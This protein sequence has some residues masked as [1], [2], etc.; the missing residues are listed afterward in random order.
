[1]L[2]KTS[3][4]RTVW[5]IGGSSG[6]G[7]A[8]VKG[9]NNSG[10]NVVAGARSFKN[11]ENVS[12]DIINS[13]INLIPLDVTDE[14]SRNNFTEE[15]LKLFPKVDALVYCAGTLLFGPCE[16]TTCNEYS[17]IMNTNFIGTVAMVQQILPVFRKQN[18]GKIIL[19]SSINGLLG[20]PFQSA[21]VA[22]KHAI[23][24]YAEC[25]TQ[26]LSAFNIEVCLIEPGDHKSG[27]QK[28]RTEYNY[29]SQDNVYI[30]N[31]D[32][33]V[34]K[35]HYDESNGSSPDILGKNIAKLI[36]KK[37]LPF[38][39]IISSTD[40]KFAVWIHRFL[41]YRLTR[42]ILVNYYLH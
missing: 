18:Y 2:K 35:I 28:Y 21:Y 40:Q 26:E 17:S 8:T 36:M 24:G 27:S 10:F 19:F 20:I 15:A 3:Q 4:K 37:H 9:L 13:S 6:L 23:E 41:P 14:S 11:T 29:K 30:K 7:L 32:K 34:D 1:M 39:L 33:A 42:K 25:L 22:S 5:V 12:K 38:R 31:Y 16:F